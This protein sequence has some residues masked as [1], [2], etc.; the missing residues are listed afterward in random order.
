MRSQVNNCVG[1]ANYKFFYL[2]LAYAY[3]YCLYLLIC[4]IIRF[5]KYY[6]EQ[7]SF[8]EISFHFIM[9]CAVSGLFF[10]FLSSLFWYHTYLVLNNRSTLEEFRSPITATGREDKCLYDMGWY[11]NLQQIFGPS[12]LLWCL[13]IYGA[14]GDGM[15]F[16]SPPP[17][18][19]ARARPKSDYV[20]DVGESHELAEYQPVNTKI[21]LNGNS[22]NGSANAGSISTVV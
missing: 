2:F 1:F 14:T 19:I 17:I 10:L 16:P 9:L 20:V 22:S 6:Q 3:L 18:V 13:P 8:A 11:K 7:V 12:F 4:L 15:H 21:V 5:V